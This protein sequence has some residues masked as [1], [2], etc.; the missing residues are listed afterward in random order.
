MVYSCALWDQADAQ[1]SLER[2]Q[3]RKVA[4][5]AD[6]LGVGGRR[7][8]DVGCGWGAVADLLLGDHG[9]ADVVGLTPSA[10]QVSSARGRAS[11]GATFLAEGWASHEPSV[12]Y[13]AI[14]CIEASE[15]FA[16][17]DLDV[18][19]KV[20][21]YRG[22]F[23]RCAAW[24]A[25][26]GRLGL[27]AICLDNVGH[28]E[29]HDPG[30]AVTGLIREEIFPE[31]M[32]SSLSE[33]ALG[34]ETHFRLESLL[35][36]PDHY[37]TTFQE[38][39][40]RLRAAGSR[41]VGLVGPSTLRS[42]E[43]YF[44]ASLLLF[45]LRQQTL[46]RIVLSRRPEPKRWAAPPSASPPAPD[47]AVAA[48]P[49]AS[50]S[51]ISSHYDLSN[52]FYRAWLG[53]SMSYSSGLWDERVTG[54]DA[55]Q[56]AKVAH[57]AQA[58]SV[59]GG[60]LLDVGCGWGA[61]LRPMVERHGVARAT[62]LTLSSAQHDWLVARPVPNTEI[63]PRDWAEHP[64]GEHYDAIICFGAFEHFA[65][66]GSTGDERV[67]AYRRFFSR[68]F[69]WLPEGGRVGLET[70]AH[71]DAPDTTSPLGRGPL[72]DF[73]LELYPESLS[74]HLCELV[75]GFEPYFLVHELRADGDDFAR[76]VRAWLRALVEHRE[77]VVADVGE[78]VYR[79][80]KTYLASSE[81]QFRMRTITNYRL[82]LERRP[83]VRW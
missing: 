9:A 4:H 53:P 83:A 24:L 21:V 30:S 25:P 47:D 74:P 51:A 79:R 31:S 22:F 78:P 73:V 39:S 71:D 60:R 77:Q 62:G 1:D 59:A 18:T 76:T 52:D 8:L 28:G 80:F 29:S 64:P 75:L 57:F 27:Q 81:V 15:H 56:A 70:I 45:R 46:Y 48:S 42:F 43:R 44:A 20:Q 37:V 72:G 61:Q 23:D 67:A 40:R 16:R 12:P 13:D 11:S 14:V 68:C 7:V 17:D 35:V 38:W 50:V 55:A 54:N 69:G 41:A 58:L 34:W 66:D 6:A 19:A 32:S 33:L 10:A 3:E 49:G 26:G 5:F 2:A 82:V 36:Q 65:T 63:E